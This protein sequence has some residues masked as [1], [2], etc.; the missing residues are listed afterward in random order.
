MKGTEK[1]ITKVKETFELKNVQKI[2][3]DLIPAI[4]KFLDKW[5]QSLQEPVI[6]AM[7]IKD[8]STWDLGDP[9]SGKAFVHTLAEHFSAL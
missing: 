6:Q 9:N 1:C 5:Y 4:S 3:T 7:R 8:H 2:K